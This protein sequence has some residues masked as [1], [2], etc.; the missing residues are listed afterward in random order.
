[1]IMERIHTEFTMD[2]YKDLDGIAEDLWENGIRLSVECIPDMKGMV[3]VV[4]RELLERAADANDLYAG[5]R[6]ILDAAETDELI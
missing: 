6:G 3:A 2:G 4:V 1:M 5:C